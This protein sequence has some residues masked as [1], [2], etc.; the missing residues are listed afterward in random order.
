MSKYLAN[1][2]KEVLKEIMPGPSQKPGR[3]E[4]Q[5]HTDNKE[6]PD[7]QKGASDGE[8]EPIACPD[9]RQ[10]QPA[11]RLDDPERPTR[12]HL[13]PRGWCATIMLSLPSLCSS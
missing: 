11:I 13:A 7:Q 3:E 6:V 9:L 2:C 12:L 8:L 4:R 10:L 1:A 5:H